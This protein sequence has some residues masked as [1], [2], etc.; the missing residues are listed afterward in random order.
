MKMLQADRLASEFSRT[1]YEKIERA[2]PE[3]H[4][5]CSGARFAAL[6][7]DQKRPGPGRSPETTAVGEAH[8]RKCRIFV[9]QSDLRNFA[10]SGAVTGSDHPHPSP[11]PSSGAKLSPLKGEGKPQKR[12]W[13]PFGRSKAP[14]GDAGAVAPRNRGSAG[15]A[16]PTS[17]GGEGKP[18]K[19][20]FK[21]HDERMPTIKPSPHA[22][23]T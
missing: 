19:R 23:S 13:Q 3:G 1:P 21:S 8:N 15:S 20:V 17:P 4:E 6:L 14:Q 7:R 2:V 12:V 18:R 22:S 11:P 10:L 9:P 16:R 5:R